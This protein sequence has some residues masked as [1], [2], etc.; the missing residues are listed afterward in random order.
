MESMLCKK[1]VWQ[2]PLEYDYGRLNYNMKGSDY[3]EMQPTHSPINVHAYYKDPYAQDSSEPHSY[4]HLSSKQNL[5][6]TKLCSIYSK[7]KACPRGNKCNFAHGAYE[8]HATADFYKTV[9]CRD[10]PNGSISDKVTVN[11]AVDADLPMA[12]K[13]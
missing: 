7:T 2:A 1:E 3:Q 13:S 11:L 6:K 9:L 5:H 4:Q 8:L 12:K 10:Y